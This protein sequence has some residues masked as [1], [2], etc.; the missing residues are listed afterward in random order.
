MYTVL[1]VSIPICMDGEIRCE[2][3]TIHKLLHEDQSHPKLKV[4]YPKKSRKIMS[5]DYC[6]PPTNYNY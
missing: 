3:F 1:D 6:A 4:Y 5:C 2:S